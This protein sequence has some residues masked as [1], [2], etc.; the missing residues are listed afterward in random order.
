MNK[1]IENLIILI[2]WA[3]GFILAY[4][5]ILKITNHSPTVDQ[6]QNTFL[7]L[8]GSTIAV[9]LVQF[10]NIYYRLG[11]LEEKVKYKLKENFK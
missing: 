4:M 5:L 11:R 1:I 7:I 2:I 6:F 10:S 8:V 3:I 9:I